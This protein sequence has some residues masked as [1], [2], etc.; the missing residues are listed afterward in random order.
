VDVTIRKGGAMKKERSRR[1]KALGW[2]A[3]AVALVLLWG[4]VKGYGFTSGQARRKMLKVSIGMEGM[5][6]VVNCGW[7][8]H[9]YTQVIGG[10]DRERYLLYA[11]AE[12]MTLVRESFELLGDGWRA[13]P[14]TGES[15]DGER[16]VK[17]R[18][19][20]LWVGTWFPYMDIGYIYF[21]C[22]GVTSDVSGFSVAEKLPGGSFGVSEAVE[23]DHGFGRAK[24]AEVGKLS[25]EELAYDGKNHAYGAFLYYIKEFKDRD[26]ECYLQ[27]E[28]TDGTVDR[29]AF[30]GLGDG[31]AWG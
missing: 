31:W 23:M 13:Y 7:E 19:L 14:M 12:R 10:P 8:D 11:N 4:I 21:R 9:R 28:W 6:P 30:P 26:R 22:D 25:S 17:V 3:L 15:C 5:A 29:V 18:D 16:A 20:T 1:S 2:S 24:S 27:V